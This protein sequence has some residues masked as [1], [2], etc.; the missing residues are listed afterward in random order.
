MESTT[1]FSQGGADRQKKRP[2]RL[3]LLCVVPP[4]ESDWRDSG[5]KDVQEAIYYYW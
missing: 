2:E 4:S 1:T 3:I 5:I